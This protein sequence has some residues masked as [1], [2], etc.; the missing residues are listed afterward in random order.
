ME[1]RDVVVV[2]SVSCIFGL[3]RPE[4]YKEVMVLI[5][6]GERRSREEILRRLVDIQYERNDIDFARGRFRVR[7]DVIEVHP[8]Y[9]DRAVRV[10]LFGDEVDRIIELDPVSGEILEEKS[11]IAIWPA[12]HWVTTDGSL[13][14][15]LRTIEDALRERVEWFKSQGKLLEA[16][17]LE[18]PA[19]EDMELLRE[20]GDYPR[21]ENYSC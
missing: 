6:K 12:K 19:K 20:V 13:E 11:A 21:I 16:Q 17:R 1:R 3:G 2:A 10:E 7:G 9:E 18:F 5:R 14:R 15:S 4:D 8:S